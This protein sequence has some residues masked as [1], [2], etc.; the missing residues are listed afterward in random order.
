MEAVTTFAMDLFFTTCGVPEHSGVLD[1]RR[2]VFQAC[3]DVDGARS[4]GIFPQIVC[5][6]SCVQA[7]KGDM[8]IGRPGGVGVFLKTINDRP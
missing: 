3:R 6:D 8:R 2:V 7:T 1:F 4:E 5:G